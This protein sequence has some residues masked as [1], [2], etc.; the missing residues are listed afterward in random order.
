M[1]IDVTP[2]RLLAALLV[3]SGVTLCGAALVAGYVVV[4]ART[5][6]QINAR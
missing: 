3:A 5:Q 1:R 4:R 6:S 2:A